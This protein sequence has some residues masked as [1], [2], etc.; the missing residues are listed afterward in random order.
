MVRHGAWRRRPEGGRER[1]DEREDGCGHRW[2][3]R[4]QGCLFSLART[5]VP[6]TTHQASTP[7]RSHA[8]HNAQHQGHARKAQGRA[9]QGPAGQGGQGG[10]REKCGRQRRRGWVGGGGGWAGAAAAAGTDRGPGEGGAHGVGRGE[11]RGG[12]V[13]GRGR[14]WRGAT[15]RLRCVEGRRAE[16]G[17]AASGGRPSARAHQ[18]IRSF[19]RPPV[20]RG[21]RRTP[22]SASVHPT[23]GPS[24]S[25][26]THLGGR[27][28]DGETGA[29]VRAREAP[30]LVL[31][32]AARQQ[33]KK[34]SNVAVTPPLSSPRAAGVPRP[35]HQPGTPT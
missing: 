17:A 27:L 19:S 34:N 31:S 22:P 9:Q 5:R 14:A 2:A 12:W 7:L 18:P 26:P 25:A 30:R 13:S 15:G 4:A 21:R 35:R 8:G 16:G 3:K 20:G 1:G 32:L 23:P 11:W 24:L 28:P 29:F 6:P 10:R 33:Q